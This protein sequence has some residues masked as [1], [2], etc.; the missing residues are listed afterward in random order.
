[1]CVDPAERVRQEKLNIVCVPTSFQV[2]PSSSAQ[3]AP[4]CCSTLQNVPTFYFRVPCG[5]ERGSWSSQARQLILQHSL[6]LSDLDRH[7]QLDV[8]IDGA[9]EVDADL[10]LIKGGG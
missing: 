4:S 9:D 5:F 1:M 3:V 2:R 8:A 7:P 10:T 6:T